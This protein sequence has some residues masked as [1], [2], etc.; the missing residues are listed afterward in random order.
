MRL[1]QSSSQPLFVR[2][3]SMAALVAFTTMRPLAA[4]T[5]PPHL[6][7]SPTYVRFGAVIVGHSETQ[8]VTVTNSEATSMTISAISVSS[9][10]FSVP[11]LTLPF[12]LAAGQSVAV[13][14]VFAPTE[15][16]WSGEESIT[17][18]NDSS[19]PGAKVV[20]A[21]VGVTNELLIATPLSL[22][23]GPVPVGTRATRSVVLKNDSSGNRTLRGFIPQSGFSVSGPEVPLTVLPGQSVTLSITFAPQVAGVEGGS[24]FIA[25]PNV[26]IPV[27][28][29]GT[30]IGQLTVSP[31][32]LNFGGVDVGS[33]TKQVFTMTA[34]GGSV[35][36][37]S[38]ASSNSQFTIPGT[39]FPMTI[40]AGQ[41][42]NFDV[43]FSPTKSGTSSGKLTLA[44]DA[45]STPSSEVLTGIGVLPQYS[46][47]LS[48]NSTTSSVS[49]YNVYRGTAAGNYSRIN[50]TLNPS[51]TYTDGTVVSGA[52]YYYAATAVN[53]QGEESGYSAP[54]KVVV[55]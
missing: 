22:S 44:S 28:G 38:A 9:A 52:T 18:M 26:D 23:F 17:F 25:G 15:T 48:W 46:V 40:G 47:S 55:P 43:V 24:V 19:G 34:T 3:A 53:S 8:V 42:V 35:A 27:T 10:K 50:T 7:F 16:G 51:T 39:S 33:T 32:T 12:V 29:T 41:S 54:L 36:I 2:L 37:S 14:V 45:S 11:N 21:G 31:T 5:A 4:Q 13:T 1:P 30:V 6:S 20:I 49:G